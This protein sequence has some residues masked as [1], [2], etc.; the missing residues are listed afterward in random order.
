MGMDRFNTIYVRDVAR[1]SQK[2]RKANAFRVG[3]RN[4]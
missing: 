2:V 1:V 4:I 3:D